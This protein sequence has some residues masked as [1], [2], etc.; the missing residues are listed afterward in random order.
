MPILAH[1]IKPALAAGTALSR[2]MPKY[3]A[4]FNKAPKSR[5]AAE[6]QIPLGGDIEEPF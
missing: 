4:T 3:D 6:E 1:K 5:K 2:H